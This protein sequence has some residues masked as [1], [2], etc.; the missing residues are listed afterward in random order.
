MAEC[1]W[2]IATKLSGDYEHCAACG[3]KVQVLYLPPSFRGVY[4]H[5]DRLVE[6]I[7]REIDR[8]VQRDKDRIRLRNIFTD[9]KHL[10]R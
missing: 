6:A 5:Q 3:K 2:M 10:D 4:Y 7:Q 8:D 9:R 1:R